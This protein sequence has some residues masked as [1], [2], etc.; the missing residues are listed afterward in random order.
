MSDLTDTPK[1]IHANCKVCGTRVTPKAKN[2]GRRLKCPDCETPIQLPTMEQYLETRRQQN[3]SE[4]RPPDLAEPYSMRE[5]VERVEA[6]V[7]VFRELAQIK[8]EEAP[9]PP[10][11]TFFSNVFEFPWKTPDALS[12]WGLLAGGFSLAGMIFAGAMNAVSLAAERLQS[13]DWTRIL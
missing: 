4:P 7:S 11:H 1:F 6:T 3:Q 13:K 9:E 10:R 5:K 12:R 2:A 8:R